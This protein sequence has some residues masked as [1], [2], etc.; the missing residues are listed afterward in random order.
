[1]VVRLPRM[2]GGTNVGAAEERYR[3][4]VPFYPA[5]VTRVAA[6]EPADLGWKLAGKRL[7]RR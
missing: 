7:A 3:L 5:T 1:M 6:V 2:S 4:N